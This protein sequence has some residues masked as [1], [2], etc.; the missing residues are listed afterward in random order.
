MVPSPVVALGQLFE[1][2]VYRAPYL[3]KG[4]P[5]LLAID[6]LGVARR[7]VVLHVG[8]NEP[9]EARKLRDLLDT[10]DPVRPISRAICRRHLELV[11]PCPAPTPLVEGAVWSPYD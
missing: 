1:R 2:G 11:K 3:V 6:S 9:E 5:A 4:I 7:H 10:L 8:M